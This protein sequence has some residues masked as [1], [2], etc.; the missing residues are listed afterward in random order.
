MA[1]IT[2]AMLLARDVKQYTNS[3]TNIFN[4][5]S[6]TVISATVTNGD[7]VLIATLPA[8]AKIVGASIQL[9]GTSAVTGIVHLQTTEPTGNTIALTPTSGAPAAPSV[10][11]ATMMTQP[12]VGRVT[13]T[14]SVT[15][16]R[17]LELVVA[18]GSLSVTNGL[19]WS[20]ECQYAFFP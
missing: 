16:T 8:N 5:F 17:D 13:G 14:L 2:T 18:S 3:I 10:A 15:G 9:L 7:R 1:Q 6:P 19:I 11:L 20:V 4:T 12:H